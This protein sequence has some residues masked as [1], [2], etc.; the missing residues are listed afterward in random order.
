MKKTLLI[1]ACFLS[2]FSF[3]QLPANSLGQDFTITD[4]EGETHNLYDILDEGKTV[5]LDLFATWCGP[6]WSFAEAGTLENL[7]SQYPDAVFCMAIEA[8][9][10]TAESTIYNSDL[11]NWTNI[12]D[13]MMADD[14]TGNIAEDYA[15][16]YY[17]TI[18][19]IC[20]DRMVTEVGQLSSVSAYLSEVNSCSQATFSKD[21]KMVSYTGG[22]TICSG[23]L[24]NLS[25]Q[26]QNYSLNSTVNNFNILT[27]VDGNTVNTTPW[28]G[29]LDT[30]ETEII[31]LGSISNI[32]ESSSVTFA[33]DFSGDM[34]TS[35]DMISSP[36]L[37]EVETETSVSVSLYIQTDYWPTE[38]EWELI[39]ES[40]NIVAQ[41][42]YTTSQGDSNF[43]YLW[44]LDYGCY[45]FNV[46]D[47]YGDGLFAS[48]W[49]DFVDGFVT[50]IDESSGGTI[51]SE[52]DYGSLGSVAFEVMPGL[53]IT[54]QNGDLLSIFPNPSNNYTNLNLQ[55][56]N[57]VNIKYSLYNSLGQIVKSKNEGIL[58][59]GNH[60]IKIDLNE[61]VEGLYFIELQIG[62]SSELHPINVVK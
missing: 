54:E 25:V 41:E 22:S 15:L 62:N 61:L 7:Q 57:N 32:D 55:L 1:I 27:M 48:Q 42:S 53:N 45:T 51:W 52:V 38:T 59:R 16:A 44:N 35:N 13:Y 47:S 56:S 11:G 19:K 58:N 8:D 5:I 21:M 6:C 40:G 3:A 34:D 60:N 12:I 17:P 4:I 29:S 50:L 36:S 24:N 31:D 9:P 30:Y 43:E 10:S 14:P 18:Y 39:D 37:S 23:S 26:V 33:I 20:P 2:T 46:Y 28:S 49:G